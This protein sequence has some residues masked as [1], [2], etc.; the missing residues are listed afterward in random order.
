MQ[1]NTPG[2]LGFGFAGRRRPYALEMTAPVDTPRDEAR[3]Q[4]LAVSMLVTFIVSAGVVVASAGVQVGVN[5]D[6][7]RVLSEA[8]SKPVDELP[9]GQA[10]TGILTSILIGGLACVTA[11]VSTTITA[12]KLKLPAL[13]GG[14]L[15]AALLLAAGFLSAVVTVTRS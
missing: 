15:V 2:C 11:V 5:L 10:A 1:P 12:K 14:F 7:L 4:K 8:H 13:P 6:A 3:G 9:A